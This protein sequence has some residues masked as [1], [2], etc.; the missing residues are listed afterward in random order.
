MNY[1]FI[2]SESELEN[3]SNTLLKEKIIGVDLEADSMHC[4]KEKICLIQIATAKQAFLIDPFE[5]KKISPFLKVL[6]NSN[7]IKI[8]HGADFDIRSLDR[9]YNTK[10]NNLFDTE[11]ACRF[12]GVKE[13]GLGALLKKNFNIESNKKYQRADW[14]NRPFKKEMI[15]YSVMDVASLTKLHGIILQKLV[16]NGRL[17]WAKEEFEIQEQ[18]KYESNNYFPLFK[19]FKGAG[20]LDN[21]SLATLENLLQFRMQAAQKKDQPLFKIISNSSIMSLALNRPDTIDKIFKLKI[22]SPRQ[23][24]MYGSFCVEAIVKAMEL[25]SEQLPSYPRTRRPKQD[26]KVKERIRHLKTMREKLSQSMGMEPGFLLNNTLIG[27][28]ASKAPQTPEDLVNIDNIR[29][30]Q[31]ENIGEDIITTL[32][33]CNS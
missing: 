9:D 8:F 12:L 27:S 13:R 32:G 15:E 33:Y 23:I 1:K 3:I 30:W 2:E 31:V 26:V 18:V 6:E 24:D 20:K 5:F 29:H 11:I 14:S 7:I 16:N 19:K 28:I 10:V 4:F 17:Q 22:L 25:N 21:R